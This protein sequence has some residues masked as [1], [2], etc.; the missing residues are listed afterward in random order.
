MKD[1][2]IVSFGCRLNRHEADVIRHE[3]REA[4]LTDTIVVNSCAV[5]AEAVAQTR[6]SIRRLRRQHPQARIVVTGCAAQTDA[7]MFAAMPEVDRVLGNADKMGS[8]AWRQAREALDGGAGDKVAVGDIMTVR[9]MAPHLSSRTVS[10]LPRAF[11]QVQNGCDHRCSFCIIPF[12]RGNS[13]SAPPDSVVGQV[14]A[15]VAQG[16]AE[17]VLTGVDLTSYG[18]DLAGCPRL[19]ALTRQ[20]LREIPELRRLRISS[21]D[22]FKADAELLD[23]IA[24]EERLMPHLH[25]SLQA[26]DDVILKR[27]KR[28]H[29]RSDA[30]AL[31]AELRLLRPDIALGADLIAGFP[32]ET[33]DMFRRSLDLVEECGLT[34]LHVFPFSSRPGT[35]AARMPQLA[36]GV[37]R[38]RA[39]RLRA[40]GAAALTR[41]L[42]SE[43]GA[44]RAVLI[45]SSTQGRTEH[46]LPVAITGAKT[47]EVITCRIAGHDRERLL[48]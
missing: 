11:A 25:L 7:A 31:C 9:A 19:G 38:E 16:H 15:L 3:A 5:T 13:R 20:I 47:G 43:R 35:V 44:S 33:E 8:E 48:L 1:I 36:A 46:F 32:T 28:R 41:R 23:A 30:I 26:G 24:T 4:G 18:T 10:A 14:R 39:T 12:G 45:E 29:S 17:I 21:I 37:I 27:M 42:E 40:A 22:S 34:F 6:Q 2:E